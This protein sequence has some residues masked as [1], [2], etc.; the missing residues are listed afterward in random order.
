LTDTPDVLKKII[1]HKQTEVASAKSAT[2]L[3][4][5]NG[6]I[7]DLE[8]QPRGFIRS[9]RT[10]RDSGWTPI[11]AEVKKGSPSKGVIREDFNPLEVAETYQNNGAACLS[12]LTDEHYF[13][14]HLRYLALIREQV[15]LPLLRKDF[16][17]DPYQI[18]EARAA[19]ADAILLIAAMLDLH[20]LRDFSAQ[21][22]E[23][24]L[25]V[26]L[27]VHDERE[28]ELALQTP[29]E[30]LGINNR[31]LRTFTID[32]G[33]TERLLKEIPPDR[34][35]V[36]ESGINTRADLE[37]LAAA[38]AGAFLIGEALMREPD[39][40]AKLREFLGS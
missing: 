1:D 24:G 2:P 12:V 19:G 40:G 32:L 26:L 30:L 8:D 9:L 6:R 16:I 7:A 18:H 38:G 11:I 4:E 34:M 35:V 22:E 3:A 20:Q 15:G 27:E 5:L 21:A 36:S 37:R 10:C 13:L 31:N 17:F 39:I 23:L 33:T 29:C 25:D 28:L 14:G